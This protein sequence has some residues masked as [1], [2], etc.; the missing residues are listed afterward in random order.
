MWG[1]VWWVCVVCACGVRVCV[2]V[3]WCVCVVGV[4]GVVYVYVVWCLCVGCV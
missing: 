4:C 2:S 3:V 1:C